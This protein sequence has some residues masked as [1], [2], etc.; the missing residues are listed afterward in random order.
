M[1]NSV[2]HLAAVTGDMGL[3]PPTCRQAVAVTRLFNRLCNK[4]TSRL[5]RKV[6]IW[7][8]SKRGVNSRGWP[9]RASKMFTNIRLPDLGLLNFEMCN[10][11]DVVAVNDT[12]FETFKNNGVL[13]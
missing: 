5:N 1:G 8:H 9:G 11:M 6:F 10:S 13:K 2:F 12:A 7:A 4:S 3:L